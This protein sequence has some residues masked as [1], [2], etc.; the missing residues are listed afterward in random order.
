MDIQP[1]SSH[2]INSHEI[3]FHEINYHQINSHEV[4]R[5][6]LTSSICHKIN[7]IFRLKKGYFEYLTKINVIDHVEIVLV[8][9]N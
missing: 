7:S 6:I 4:T 9:L 2:E 3:N 1:A 8:L 5:Q